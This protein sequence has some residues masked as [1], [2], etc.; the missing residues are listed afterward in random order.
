V[1]NIVD[2]YIHQGAERIRNAIQ[3]GTVFGKYI[4]MDDPDM[5]LLA[6]WFLGKSEEGIERRKEFDN[7]FDI[8]GAAKH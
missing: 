2:D 6:V 4:D 1:S 5:V 3:G 7:L 8:L